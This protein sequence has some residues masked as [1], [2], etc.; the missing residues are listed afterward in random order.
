MYAPPLNADWDGDTVV[1]SRD[2]EEQ[3]RFKARR[4]LRSDKRFIDYN[5]KTKGVVA[6]IK[7]L[8]YWCGRSLT[9]FDR[10]ELPCYADDESPG[11]YANFTMH[12]MFKRN[13]GFGVEYNGFKPGTEDFGFVQLP[14]YDDYDLAPAKKRLGINRGIFRVDSETADASA[15]LALGLQQRW[16]AANPN[17]WFVSISSNYYHV[18]DEMV[19]WAASLPNLVVGHTVGAWFGVDELENRV[20]AIRHFIE[21]GVNAQVWLATRPNWECGPEKRELIDEALSLV[22]PHQVIAVAY[23]DKS[24]GHEE[25][26]EKINPM[27]FCCDGLFDKKGRRVQKDGMVKVDGRLEEPCGT[28][29]GKCLG[30]PLLCGVTYELKKR[31][32][33]VA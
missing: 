7:D 29:V 28:P 3:G 26:T 19:T 1:V 30:C 9:G 6:M 12:A 32:G 17:D 10:C 14:K 2:G 31:V 24:V 13:Q 21:N 16:A 25:Q 27:G 15:S 33:A 18:S 22:K 5:A 8:Q 23:H 11:C 4:K 20:S